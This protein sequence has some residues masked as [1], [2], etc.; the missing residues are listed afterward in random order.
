MLMTQLVS[1]RS[2]LWDMTHKHLRW[3]LLAVWYARHFCL[4]PANV[5]LVLISFASM[6]RGLC[7]FLESIFHFSLH[8]AY[9]VFFGS[10]IL[11]YVFF[12]SFILFYVFFGSFI[13]FYVY[14]MLEHA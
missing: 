5:C 9:N 3:V 4:K 14:L 12:G 11:F 13:L 8:N 7:L 2:V 6:H 10:F 1:R